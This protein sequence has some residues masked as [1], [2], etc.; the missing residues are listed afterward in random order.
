MTRRRKATDG[1][2]LLTIT[3]PSFQVE[4]MAQALDGEADGNASRFVGKHEK[5]GVEQEFAG[6]VSGE[7]DGTPY[8]GDFKEEPH[9]HKQK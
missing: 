1:K 7:V 8:A 9:E 5:L 2:L 4:L 6:T 3:E